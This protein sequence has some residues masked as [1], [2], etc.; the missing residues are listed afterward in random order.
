MGLRF[1]KVERQGL[2]QLLDV[3][4][5]STSV[6]DSSG[7]PLDHWVTAGQHRLQRCVIAGLCA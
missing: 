5:I 2:S 4:A 6:E 7:G 3:A 1:L